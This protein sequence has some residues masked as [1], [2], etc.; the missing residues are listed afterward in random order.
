[1]KSRESVEKEKKI[2]LCKKCV[3][4]EDLYKANSPRIYDKIKELVGKKG[5]S[6]K[7]INTVPKKI[8]TLECSKHRTINILSQLGEVLLRVI[9]NRLRGKINERFSKE[10]YGFRKGKG[11]TNAIFA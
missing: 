4:I 1:M 5:I 11:T 7:N 6:R 3:E 9:I 8:G 2:G 10:Q